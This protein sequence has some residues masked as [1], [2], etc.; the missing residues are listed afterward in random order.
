MQNLFWKKTNQHDIIY[1]VLLTAHIKLVLAHNILSHINKLIPISK[2]VESLLSQLNQCYLHINLDPQSGIEEHKTLKT[3]FNHFQSKTIVSYVIKQT[4]HNVHPADKSWNIVKPKILQKTHCYAH[5]FIEGPFWNSQRHHLQYLMQ[6]ESWP[7]SPEYIIAFSNKGFPFAIDLFHTISP[8]HYVGF[9]YAVLSMSSVFSINIALST[10]VSSFNIDALSV[11]I[12]RYF[13]KVNMNHKFIS[14]DLSDHERGKYLKSCD[15]STEFGVHNRPPTV[16]ECIFLSLSQ[17]MNF[18]YRLN[19]VYGYAHVRR[20]RSLSMDYLNNDIKPNRRVIVEH[21]LVFDQWGYLIG[22]DRLNVYNTALVGPFDLLTWVG[23]LTSILSLSFLFLLLAALKFVLIRPPISPILI[24]YQHS[25]FKIVEQS[26]NIFTNILGSLL[27]QSV[28]AFVARLASW[29]TVNK[30]AAFLWIFWTFSVFLLGQLYKGK[31]FSF[32]TKAPEPEYPGDLKSLVDLNLMIA[33]YT[34][35]WFNGGVKA[36]VKLYLDEIMSGVNVSYP[37]YYTDFNHS[38]KFYPAWLNGLRKLS[39]QL[40]M[41]DN[42]HLLPNG[43]MDWEK[44]PQAFASFDYLRHIHMHKKVLDL[45]SPKKWI[46]L[47]LPVDSYMSTMPWTVNKNYFY[48]LFL[49][50]MSQIYESGLYN[51]WDAYHDSINGLDNFY[52][53]RHFIREK[54]I[55]DSSIYTPV[56]REKWFNYYYYKDHSSRKIGIF[57]DPEAVSVRVLGIIW[58]ILAILIGFSV[59]L[60][61]SEV[62]WNRSER[63]NSVTVL[64]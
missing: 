27:D 30:F 2:S 34:G 46:S 5:I 62:L 11:E 10:V 55:Q 49:R 28:P 58:I 15:Y 25:P 41:Q 8:S 40:F 42:Q 54:G 9:C 44:V 53:V 52:W 21:G 16:E 24:D 22:K 59:I 6:Q 64:Q 7:V 31:M 14:S 61:L 39:A 19:G 26:S 12:G 3:L 18:T 48:P 50:G 29:G 20:R 4:N 63:K 37:S 38:L 17:N 36:T 57:E 45:Y 47:V 13:Q 23:I 51:R 33:T 1:F 43:T 60:L 56:P 35:M 32:L